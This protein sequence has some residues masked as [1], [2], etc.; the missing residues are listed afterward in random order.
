MFDYH[1]HQIDDRYVP[2]LDHLDRL[3]KSRMG[4][5]RLAFQSAPGNWLRSL[6]VSR[7]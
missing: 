7:S 3:T 4:G 6:G 1:L 5:S 2:D